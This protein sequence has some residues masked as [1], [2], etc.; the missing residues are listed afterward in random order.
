MIEKQ[1]VEDMLQIAVLVL[2]ALG[3]LHA[4]YGRLIELLES[5]QRP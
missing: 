1:P 2:F 4:G 3:T 5:S